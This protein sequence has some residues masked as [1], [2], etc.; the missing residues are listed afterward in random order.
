MK[1]DNECDI[2]VAQTKKQPSTPFV[3]NSLLVSTTKIDS[4]HLLLRIHP[5][6]V[7]LGLLFNLEL[8]Q[9]LKVD[10]VVLDAPAGDRGGVALADLDRAVA[11][12][13]QV[14]AALDRLPEVLEAVL[15]VH[16]PHLALNVVGVVVDP[17]LFLVVLVAD[18]VLM[19]KC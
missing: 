4:P 14:A 16:L 2:L 5:S 17:A 1:V 8:A 13:D 11:L 15:H 3:Y 10:A 6:L 7:V 19:P 12:D 9:L 18:H